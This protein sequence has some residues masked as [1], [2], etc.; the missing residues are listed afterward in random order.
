M[1]IRSAVPPSFIILGLMASACADSTGD[2][3]GGPPILE[4][5][6]EPPSADTVTA[7]DTVV[8]ALRRPDGT[9]VAHESIRFEA[10]ASGPHPA[11]LYLNELDGGLYR[12]DVDSTDA[13][14]HAS[15]LLTRG[16]TPGTAWLVVRVPNFAMS[17]SISLQMLPGN[18]AALR[19]TPADTA[20][21]IGDSLAIHAYV[22]DQYGNPRP[23]EVTFIAE[24]TTISVDHTVGTATVTGLAY[25]RASILS[26]GAGQ[27]LRTWVS[28]V[29]N[30]TI[31]FYL[32][33]PS[34]GDSVGIGLSAIDGSALHW[35]YASI[36]DYVSGR[37]LDWAPDG[38]S[39]VFHQGSG[40]GRARL[41]TITMDGTIR[42]LIPGGI[43]GAPELFPRYGPDG[44]IYFT[45]E[46]N[47][48]IGTDELWRV[49]SDGSSPERIGLP[50]ADYQSDTYSGPAPDS[51]HVWFS[52]D[53]LGPSSV[54]PSNLAVLHVDSG[55]VKFFAFYGIGAVWSPVGDRVAFIDRNGAIVVCAPDG[56]GQRVV[57]SALKSYIPYMD[58]S[59]DG[60]WIVAAWR[61]S[62]TA[63]GGL[64]V[65]EPDLGLTLPL[66]FARYWLHPAWRP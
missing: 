51:E 37:M 1:H 53:R 24:S 22:M 42:A 33:A 15:V 49:N 5:I 35:L 41:Y 62:G 8:V 56:T 27:M 16:A 32:Q 23:E 58:W 29:P 55:T 44:R 9:P 40:A 31:A 34:T 59:P 54:E 17:D 2:D 45:L 63:N 11:L 20:L 6:S 61:Q 14:G 21:R 50:A 57:S 3:H 10:T 43:G 7:Q 66:A 28:V 18:P 30:G 60:K 38:Q 48:T 39:L 19:V 12:V 36:Y 52:T 13:N 46:I 26:T 47:E 25:G 64:D 65:I 4:F